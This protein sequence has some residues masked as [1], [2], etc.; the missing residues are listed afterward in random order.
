MLPPLS[1]IILYH[2]IVPLSR[3]WK[4]MKVHFELCGAQY[5][6]KTI[7]LGSPFNLAYLGVLSFWC[8]KGTANIQELDLQ[9]G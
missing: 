1:P 9:G 5:M 2:H 7:H 8:W 4:N 6:V 3:L